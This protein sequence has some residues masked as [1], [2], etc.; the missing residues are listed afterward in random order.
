MGI[1]LHPLIHLISHMYM[2]LQLI[3]VDLRIGLFFPLGG[4]K[5][6]RTFVKMII[7]QFLVEETNT[8]QKDLNFDLQTSNNYTCIKSSLYQIYK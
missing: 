7:S 5:L 2:L 3:L 6:A 8:R 4:L 1:M